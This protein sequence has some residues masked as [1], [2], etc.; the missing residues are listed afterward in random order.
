MHVCTNMSTHIHTDNY[1]IKAAL[2]IPM[3]TCIATINVPTAQY[4]MYHDNVPYGKHYLHRYSGLSKTV[5]S[6]RQ[7]NHISVYI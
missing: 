6:S 3:E 1:T 5:T 4:I 2:D 7:G